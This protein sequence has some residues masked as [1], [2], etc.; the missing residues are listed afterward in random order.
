MWDKQIVE[1]SK[2]IIH[3]LSFIR[4]TQNFGMVLFLHFSRFTTSSVAYLFLNFRSPSSMF[5]G[6]N[7]L[8]L[9]Y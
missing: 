5:L 7:I 9:V 3:A 6:I 2:E 1:L 4:N 8:Y